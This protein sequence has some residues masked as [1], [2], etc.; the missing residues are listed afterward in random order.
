MT[1]ITVTTPVPGDDVTPSYTTCTA[2][3]KFS[4]NG[5]KYILYYKNLGGGALTASFA[6]NTAAAPTGTVPTAAANATNWADLRLSS[7]IPIST[8]GV[9]IIPDVTPYLDVN[10]FVNLKHT[11][12]TGTP[13]VAVIGPL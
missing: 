9:C 1:T 2:A 5:G 6:L 13:S 8:D 12:L 10:N 3:D 4:A 7:G 11:G